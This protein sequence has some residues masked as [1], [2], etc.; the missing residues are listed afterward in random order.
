MDKA[1][2]LVFGTSY[3]G[4]AICVYLLSTIIFITSVILIFITAFGLLFAVLF[5]IQL[6]PLVI[7]AAMISL[8]PLF[9]HI[10]VEDIRRTKLIKSL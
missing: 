9:I 4:K 3:L 8:V 1:I 7:I 5:K 2:G 10:E 6:V